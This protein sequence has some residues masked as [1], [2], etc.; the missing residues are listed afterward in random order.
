MKPIESYWGS[1]NPLA[2]ILTPVSWCFCLTAWLRRQLYKTG[3]LAV[4]RAP[5]PVLI[6]GNIT[7][8]GTGK[9]PLVIWL[10]DLLI[11]LGYRPGIVSRGYRGTSD[12]WPRLVDKHSDPL[13]VGDEAVL[14][15]RR[16]NRPVAVGP[17]RPAAVRELIEQAD[18]DIII[19][20]DGLQHYALARDMEIAV[21]DGERRLGNGLCLPS[22]PLRERASRLKTVDL[23]ITNGPGLEGEH[24]MKL[25]V[26]T[27]VNLE[28]AGLNRALEDFI[29]GPVHAVAGIGN[30]ARFFKTLRQ[31][32][33][34]VIEH[35]FPDHHT[36]RFSD[37][38]FK[39]EFPVLMTEKDAVK[40]SRFAKVSHWYLKVD[41][42]L[43]PGFTNQ[44]TQLLRDIVNG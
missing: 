15:A 20:D 35:P 28:D 1:R 11:N 18:C 9:T 12:T 14:L 41:A 32:G 5:V 8:G 31:T 33:L 29:G 3:I 13:E 24:Q 23:I 7:V 26:A 40:C 34:E 37:I 39:D 27:A 38:S 19:S 17:D 4:Y 22:G 25:S 30:P 16:T 43:S 44:L 36:F 10:V 21:I 2:M 42:D 6:V